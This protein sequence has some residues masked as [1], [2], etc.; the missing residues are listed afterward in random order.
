VALDTVLNFSYVFNREN[1]SMDLVELMEQKL[2]F[3]LE[4]LDGKTGIEIV[5]HI[6]DLYS[7]DD[8]ISMTA[9]QILSLYGNDED[10]VF[11]ESPAMQFLSSD[12]TAQ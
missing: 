12:K 5:E 11:K 10:L 9:D 4:A 1:V 3:D 8:E 6:K 2:I 7:S